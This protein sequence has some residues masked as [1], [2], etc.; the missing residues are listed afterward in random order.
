MIDR[1]WTPT[2]WRLPGLQ[3]LP[4]EERVALLEEVQA[5]TRWRRRLTI[6]VIVIWFAALIAV[7]AYLYR[8]SHWHPL[9]TWL[10]PWVILVPLWARLWRQRGIARF[11][12]ERLRRVREEEIGSII[13]TH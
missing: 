7:A 9:P 12:R 3:N 5:A 1:W 2:L 8:E 13:A 10:V 4:D 6:A 11:V